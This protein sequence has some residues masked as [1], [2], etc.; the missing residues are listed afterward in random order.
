MEAQATSGAASEGKRL[1]RHHVSGTEH[2]GVGMATGTYPSD[3]TIPYP[4]P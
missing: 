3:S 1:G 2:E 4:Y